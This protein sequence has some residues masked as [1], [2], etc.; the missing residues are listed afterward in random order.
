MDDKISDVFNI[1]PIPPERMNTVHLPVVFED[2]ATVQQDAASSRANLKQLIDVATQAL[3]GAL[4]VAL[5]SESP[6]A[7]EVL[8]TLITAS[9]DLNTKLMG[10]HEAETKIVGK[11]PEVVNNTQNITTNVVFSGTTDALQDLIAQRMKGT[12]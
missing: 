11:K 6:R 1:E 2:H 8:A 3:E 5:T 7:Y 10:T 12:L 4:N 9:S